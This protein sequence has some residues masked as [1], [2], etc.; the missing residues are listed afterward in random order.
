V[1]IDTRFLH[2]LQNGINGVCAG[3]EFFDPYF[4]RS[5]VKDADVGER[6]SDVHG[7][8]DAVRVHFSSPRAVYT[9][10]TTADEPGI[11]IENRDWHLHQDTNSINWIELDRAAIDS[12]LA[13]RLI[14]GEKRSC[15]SNDFFVG[16]STPH[17]GLMRQPCEMTAAVSFRQKQPAPPPTQ[18]QG[19]VPCF[20]NRDRCTGCSGTGGKPMARCTAGSSRHFG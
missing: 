18:D 15:L 1:K 14:G 19:L 3:G 20:R 10:R 12:L 16:R 4:P 7:H 2:T 17:H 8:P 5:I 6:P 13:S 11:A 9:N